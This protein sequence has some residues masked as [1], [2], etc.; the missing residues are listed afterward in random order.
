VF[1]G[2]D[3]LRAIYER[4]GVSA[5]TAN[6]IYCRTGM[7][8]SVDYFVLKYLGYDAILY[9]GSFIEWSKAGEQVD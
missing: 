4:A 5:I 7:Q 2:A 6:I 1:L 8:A 9:D 3:R